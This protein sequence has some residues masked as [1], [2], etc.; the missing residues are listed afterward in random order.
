MNDVW[1]IRDDLNLA[2]DGLYDGDVK[3][4]GLAKCDGGQS[5]S[6]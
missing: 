3:K 4:S 6:V 1:M 5:G 2:N